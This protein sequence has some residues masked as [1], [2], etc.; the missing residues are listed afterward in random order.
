MQG[1]LVLWPTF[2]QNLKILASGKFRRFG[3]MKVRL[4]T[5]NRGDY[6]MQLR[7]FKVIGIVGSRP[8]ERM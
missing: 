1:N 3:D 4:K 2:V 5:Q 8:I 7:S 6:K